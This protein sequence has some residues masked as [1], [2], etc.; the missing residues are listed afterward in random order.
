MSSPLALTATQ[1]TEKRTFLVTVLTS[2][3]PAIKPVVTQTLQI[4]VSP[5]VNDTSDNWYEKLLHI[6]FFFFFI[7]TDENR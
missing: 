6:S 3:Q 7:Q 2:I 1:G 5:T 4:P